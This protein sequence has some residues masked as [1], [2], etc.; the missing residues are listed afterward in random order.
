[1]IDKVPLVR[2]QYRSIEGYHVFTSSDVYG[3]YIASQDLE[4][5]R[6][7]IGAALRELLQTNYSVVAD[8]KLAASFSEVVGSSCD[9]PSVQATQGV[10][11]E[12]LL[13]AVVS[14]GPINSVIFDASKIC[15]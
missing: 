3:L 12:E 8:V 9:E 1:M 5:A 10:M 11:P 4:A 13:F 7:R 6:H 14:N 2:V 15:G